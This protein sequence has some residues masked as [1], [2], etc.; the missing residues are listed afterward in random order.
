VLTPYVPPTATTVST[1]AL[2]ASGTVRVTSMKIGQAYMFT[3]PNR[4]WHKTSDDVYLDAHLSGNRSTLFVVEFGAAVTDP[5]LLFSNTGLDPQWM[6]LSLNDPSQLPSTHGGSDP[7]ARKYSET[8]Y[9]VVLDARYVAGGLSVIVTANEGQTAKLSIPVGP[10][11]NMKT[12]SVPLFMFGAYE[13]MLDRRGA[14]VTKETHG[15]MGEEK[16]QEHWAKYPFSTFLNTLHPLQ[17]IQSDYWI[18]LPRKSATGRAKPAFR[19]RYRDD[20]SRPIRS[21][22]TVDSN[23]AVD[24]TYADFFAGESSGLQFTYMMSRLDGEREFSTHY[25]ASLIYRD[26]NGAFQT[27]GGGLGGGHHGSGTPDFK[28]VFYHEQGHAFGMGHAQSDYAMDNYPYKGGALGREGGNPASDWG[29]DAVRN[30]F[31]DV[32]MHTDA[33]GF[34]GTS[35]NCTKLK[36]QHVTDDGKIKCY[37]QSVMQGGDGDQ[38]PDMNF[39]QLADYNLAEILEHIEGSMKSGTSNPSDPLIVKDGGRIFHDECTCGNY[40]YHNY[41]R[42]NNT[43]QDFYAVTL[44]WRFPHYFKVPLVL[45]WA[46]I[47]CAELNCRYSS[48]PLRTSA[49]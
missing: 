14:T 46:T 37:K 32:F 39:G 17:M 45:I 1:P 49:T 8:A 42:W 29:Y 16:A 40:A 5:K 31:I 28:G 11:I 7:M 44:T 38:E 10:I 22:Y 20:M 9:S 18:I 43:A 6:Q 34:E 41:R 19:A 12:F 30:E 4:S 23:A 35:T 26:E 24:D 13:S 2:A 47:S 15:W 33:Y 27:G 25:Y 21:D 36:R 3:A 48:V